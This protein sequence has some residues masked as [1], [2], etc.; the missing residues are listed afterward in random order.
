L[1]FAIHVSSEFQSFCP[2]IFPVILALVQ[3]SSQSTQTRDLL[4]TAEKLPPTTK[5]TTTITTT[6]TTTKSVLKM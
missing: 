2:V 5:T 3:Q 1:H 4:A 6:T